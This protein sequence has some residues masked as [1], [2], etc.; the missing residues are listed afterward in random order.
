[1]VNSSA[2][3]NPFIESYSISMRYYASAVICLFIYFLEP[4]ISFA[5]FFY[6]KFNPLMKKSILHNLNMYTQRHALDPS[7]NRSLLNKSFIFIHY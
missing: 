5:F 6:P 3:K 1:M 4:T 7:M 2:L